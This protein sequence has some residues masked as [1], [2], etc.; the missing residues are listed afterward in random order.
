MYSYSIKLKEML[1]HKVRQAL[2]FNAYDWS[3]KICELCMTVTM[4]TYGAHLVATGQTSS[5]DF[6]S[7]VIYQLTLA[8]CLEGLTSV[9]TGLM[10]A[11]GAS[12][13]IFEYLDI[14][15]ALQITR[16]FEP[17]TLQGSIEFKNVHFSYPTRPEMPIL[18]GISF[19][20]RP[21]EVVALVGPSGSGKSSCVS[22]LERFYKPDKGEIL[23]DG[24]PVN[25][26][27]HKFIHRVIA[28]VGQEPVLYARKISENIA[29]GL[30][31]DF[32]FEKIEEASKMANA[33]NFIVDTPKKY[34][35]ECGER[36]IQLSG[37]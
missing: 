35:T 11:A 1:K 19:S 7:F 18:K 12:E 21:G 15:P 24:I 33:H 23:I 3:V 4:L 2:V 22:L 6:I 5:G 17:D 25:D 8:T 32:T 10:N 37:N 13:K 36:G 34:D 27:N 20:V 29:Y 28:L 31:E 16:A 26:Y 30:E 14:K 9:Y